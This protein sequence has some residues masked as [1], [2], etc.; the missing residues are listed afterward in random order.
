MPRAKK[1]LL[2]TLSWDFTAGASQL[3]WNVV[4]LS[5]RIKRRVV[6]E[7]H[8]LLFSAASPVSAAISSARCADPV[9]THFY[10]RQS[11]IRSHL[12]HAPELQ[13][14][15]STLVHCQVLSFVSGIT[16][17]TWESCWN[18]SFTDWV[19]FGCCQIK[20]NK[21][22]NCQICNYTACM[23]NAAVFN[24]ILFFMSSAN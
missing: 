9:S 1:A 13:H 4:D 19:L 6:I 23:T 20:S 24:D 7:Q 10:P 15:K 12:S 8:Q 21:Q 2:I 18:K 14:N 16:P 17:K 3:A 11:T 5:A 22:L